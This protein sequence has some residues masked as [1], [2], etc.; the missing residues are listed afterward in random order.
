MRKRTS[1]KTDDD[2][3]NKMS[4]LEKELKSGRKPPEDFRNKGVQG[5]ARATCAQARFYQQAGNRQRHGA[6]C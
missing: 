2:I 6:H 1:E 3:R 5:A 4:R